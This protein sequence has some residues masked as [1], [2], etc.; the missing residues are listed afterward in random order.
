MS[1]VFDGK[2]SNQP[3]RRNMSG[4][5]ICA[6]CKTLIEKPKI[7][8]NKVEVPLEDRTV[9]FHY[10][11]YNYIGTP[12]FIYESNSGQSVVYCSDYCRKKHNHRFNK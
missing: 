11:S 3:I 7:G 12:Y 1:Y 10:L 8:T 2:V 4:K 5:L 6:C 9:L